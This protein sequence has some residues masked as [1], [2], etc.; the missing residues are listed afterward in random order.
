MADAFSEFWARY[1]KREAKADAL[2]AWLKLLPTQETVAAIH[3]AL[4]WQ[5]ESP[6]WTKQRGQYV[7]LA[8]SY[9]RGRR[10]E[11]ERRSGQARRAASLWPEGGCPHT[12]TCSHYTPC[13]QRIYLDSERAKRRAG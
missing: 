4:D 13:Q 7:P 6:D 9:L 1:P 11:D 3:A 2:K 5:I 8:G 10:W 12:P